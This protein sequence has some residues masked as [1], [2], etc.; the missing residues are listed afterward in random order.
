MTIRYNA[1]R[2]AR[3]LY[4]SKAVLVKKGGRGE[5]VIRRVYIILYYYI[6][7]LYVIDKSRLYPVL[8]LLSEAHVRP[9][10]CCTPYK[11]L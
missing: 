3:R 11:I 5:M 4:S 6:M 1:C 2:R 10:Y 8:S 9:H 7:C